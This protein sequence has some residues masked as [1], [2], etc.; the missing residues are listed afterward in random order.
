MHTNF[1]NLQQNLA[2][3]DDD[4]WKERETAVLSLGA[5]AEGCIAGLYP[6]LPQVI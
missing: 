6:H 1:C 2:R 4:S 3:T 5:I